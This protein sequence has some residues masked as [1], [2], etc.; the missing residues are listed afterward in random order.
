MTQL[1]SEVQQVADASVNISEESQK[2]AELVQQGNSIVCHTIEQMK[3]IQKMV[4]N[5]ANI[6][7]TLGE[8]SS[9]MGK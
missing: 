2:G 5:G 6:L 7:I 3:R 4:G 8:G 9:E 1:S